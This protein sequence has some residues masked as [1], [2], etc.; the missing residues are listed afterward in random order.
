MTFRSW[1]DYKTFSQ[2]L[3]GQ[4][5]FSSS[6]VILEQSIIILLLTTAGVEHCEISL[7]STPL[8]DIVIVV[9]IIGVT[10]NV[11]VGSVY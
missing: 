9:K 8:N 2:G 4:K 7:K 3:S 6:E 1:L 11:K 5:S 10:V